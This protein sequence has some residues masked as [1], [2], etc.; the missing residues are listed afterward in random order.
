MLAKQRGVLMMFCRINGRKIVCFAVGILSL[1]VFSTL[2][3]G[4]T[5]FSELLSVRNKG[6]LNKI[7]DEAERMVKNNPKDKEALLTLG[8]A[9]HNLGDVG[10][11]TGPEKSVEYLEKAKKLDPEDAFVGALLGSST[12][13]MGRYSKWKVT[14]GRKLVGKGGA[15]LDRAVMKSPDD[16][17]VRMVRANNAFGLP[18]FFGRRHYFKEDLQHI[19]ELIKKSPTEYSENFKATVYFKLGEACEMEGEDSL[20]KSYFKKAVE[21][22]P[23]SISGKDAKKRL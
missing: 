22:A 1:F 23:D 9:Y 18:K 10:V 8:I 20:A 4:K 19:E 3:Y 6:E 13:M 17:L 11:E 21:V 7:I 2:V 5:D 15:M 14:T 12:T 16:A